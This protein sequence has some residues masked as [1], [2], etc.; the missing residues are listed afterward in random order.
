ML[1]CLKIES[2]LWLHAISWWKLSKIFNPLFTCVCTLVRFAHILHIIKPCINVDNNNINT[3]NIKSIHLTMSYTFCLY[4]ELFQFKYHHSLCTQYKYN[5]YIPWCD[6]SQPTEITKSTKRY[7]VIN[8][9][10]DSSQSS[11]LVI[12]S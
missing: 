9:N 2:T 1:D 3:K 11:V 8:H 7:N 6:C 4:S 5:S 10:N 12:L